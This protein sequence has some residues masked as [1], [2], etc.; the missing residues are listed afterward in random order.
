LLADNA[1]HSGFIY[2]DI[3]A[4]TRGL[5]AFR[6]LPPLSGLNLVADGMGERHFNN[7]ARETRAL[8]CIGFKL[9]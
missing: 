4:A 5:C 3:H 7:R 1:E 9:Y 2:S 8:C 6:E